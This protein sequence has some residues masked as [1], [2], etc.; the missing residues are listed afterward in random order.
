MAKSSER[1][2]VITTTGASNHF[3][4]PSGTWVLTVTADSWGA[5]TLENTNFNDSIWIATQDAN[6]AVA[7]AEDTDVQVVGGRSYRLNVSSLTDNI[8]FTRSRA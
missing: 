2:I 1:S 5:A 8:T 7:F 6:G 4:L 3:D